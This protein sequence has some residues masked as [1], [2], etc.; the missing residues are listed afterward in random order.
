MIIRPYSP[1]KDSKYVNY[2]LQLN[3]F[4]L[5]HFRL[6]P[7]FGLVAYQNDML[8]AIGFAREIEGQS[9]MLD[10]YMT[11]PM[12]SPELRNK[13]LNLITHKLI[14]LSEFHDYKLICFSNDESIIRRAKE[15]GFKVLDHKVLVK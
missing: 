1:K 10:S 3:N 13:A 9:Y 7:Q 8:V 4:H 5:S 11:N 6:L 12:W 14:K 2:L 15:H